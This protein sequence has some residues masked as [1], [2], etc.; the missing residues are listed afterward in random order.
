MDYVYP[1]R[2]GGDIIAARSAG[3]GNVHRA[4]APKPYNADTNANLNDLSQLSSNVCKKLDKLIYPLISII[5][6]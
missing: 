6:Y 4:H 3:R 1:Y 5:F 2:L